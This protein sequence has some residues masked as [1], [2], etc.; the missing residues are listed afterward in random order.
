[1][2]TPNPRQSSVSPLQEI[3]PGVSTPSA[4]TAVTP[5][6]SIPAT[7]VG[8]QAGLGAPASTALTTD[9]GAA[10][11]DSSAGG[12]LN[13]IFGDVT[14]ALSSPLGELAAYGG[15]TAY[16]LSQAQQAQQQNQQY[17]NQIESASQPFL[18]AGTSLLNQAMSGKL[19]SYAQS[20]VNFDTTQGQNIINSGQALQTIAQQN[21]SQYSSGNLKPA[22]QL[23]LDQQT[24]AQKQQV[25]SQLAAGGNVDSSVM[26][27]YTQQIDQTAA[28]TKQNILNSYYT[29][30][31]SAYNSW[32]TSTAQGAQLMNE[33]SQFAQ[34]TF[35]SMM[36]NALGLDQVGMSGLTTAIGL[37]IQSN[38]QLSNEVSNLM[39]NIAAAYAY[40][41]AGPGRATS[42]SGGSSGGG[43]SNLLGSA[44]KLISDLLGNSSGLGAALGS[45]AFNAAIDS[46]IA[47]GASSAVS[48]SLASTG[49]SIAA[50]NDAALA[51]QLTSEGITPIAGGDA[52]AAGGA[53]GVAGGAA[54]SGA[55][56]AEAAAATDFASGGAAGAAGAGAG[57]S[58][59]GFLGPL[60]LG[61]GGIMATGGLNP[62]TP[63]SIDAVLNDQAS[64]LKMTQAG[65][66][67]AASLGGGLSS[68]SAGTQMS[69]GGGT[70][71]PLYTY[72]GK[73]FT[74]D[75]ATA[76][77]LWY[78]YK[79]GTGTLSDYQQYMAAHS[80]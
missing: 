78:N 19:P 60:A 71:Q 28:I 64:G 32:L 11:S 21:F 22:D 16:G 25:A 70:Q 6:T 54:A 77:Q 10:A 29:T 27:A 15:L 52:A 44:G 9:T 53:A 45:S 13:S 56:G 2:S 18:N 72:N 1:M 69:L 67:T 17:A 35:Q 40:T 30:G 5:P 33:G 36:Q 51:S 4:S 43:V 37:E 39:S 63:Q 73:P 74:G 68:L 31:D 38:T 75:S 47:S 59:L 12:I 65:G 24:A 61:I 14:S 66:T 46:G 20:I 62:Q 79:H 76:A 49:A 55:A 42:S 80:K 26:A 23:A 34:Q 41:L 58:A 3:M 50:G 57:A 8:A 48:G 7:N